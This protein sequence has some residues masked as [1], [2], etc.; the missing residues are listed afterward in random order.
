MMWRE[1]ATRF[2]LWIMVLA[3][4]ILLGGKLFDNQVLVGAWSLSPPE[5]L[6][7]LPY[8][9]RWPVD[10]GEY[11]FPSSVA[12]LLCSLLVIV[13]GW[14]TPWSF[15]IWLIIPGMMILGVLIFTITWFWPR[16]A[17][18]WAIA[19]G[20]ANAVQDREVIVRMVNEWVR[21]DWIRIVMG[22]T[23]LVSSIRA[24]SVPYPQGS[25]SV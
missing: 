8:G 14:K 19:K 18:L 7:L 22:M 4:G 11:F 21:Y 20:S 15:R 24:I 17:E 25:P 16:N 5:S 9:S 3:G 23:G 13:T 2:L 1:R 6:D 10:T 12:W